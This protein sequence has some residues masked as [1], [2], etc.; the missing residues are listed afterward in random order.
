MNQNS[1]FDKLYWFCVG[2]VTYGMI[3]LT[4]LVW[5]PIPKENIRFADVIL[6]FITG[7]LVTGAIGFLLGGTAPTAK[8][9]TEPGTTTADISAT[10][11]TD[12]KD[13]KAS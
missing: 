1:H 9:P 2:I 13:A 4:A 7:S 10:I 11:T 3:F 12:T 8:K 5:M 6:G